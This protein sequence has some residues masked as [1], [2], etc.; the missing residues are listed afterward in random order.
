MVKLILS[1]I[2]IFMRFINFILWCI[3]GDTKKSTRINED[4]HCDY[5][6][7]EKQTVQTTKTYAGEFI[8]DLHSKKT[9]YDKELDAYIDDISRYV[10]GFEAR[11]N[12]YSHKGKEY[13]TERL[14][15]IVHLYCLKR[16]INPRVV[17]FPFNHDGYE[18]I[19]DS[20]YVNKLTAWESKGEFEKSS[21]LSKAQKKFSSWVN[22]S[23]DARR[24]L[25]YIS[26]SINFYFN[27]SVIGLKN[28]ALCID[29]N[30]IY[31]TNG[32]PNYSKTYWYDVK[33]LSLDRKSGVL[34]INENESGIIV[35][36]AGKQL[37]ERA[38]FYFR[39]I[40][41]MPQNKIISRL[42]ISIDAAYKFK[43]K[44][45]EDLSRLFD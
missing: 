41:N 15:A 42:D 37:L 7:N 35:S 16:H 22:E 6:K 11:I 40:N 13:C 39:E 20:D 3:F 44:Y 19:F 2:K 4:F 9:G 31:I 38:C 17:F 29:N 30:A 36:S 27:C 8:A 45:G 10:E 28:N 25:D 24:V 23:D 26:S 1:F 12:S 32:V 14:I 33:E 43:E 18:D 5:G 34:T 21:D